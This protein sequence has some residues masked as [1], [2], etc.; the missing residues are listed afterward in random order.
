M[1]R[2]VN[3]IDGIV[4]SLKSQ[5]YCYFAKKSCREQSFDKWLISMGVVEFLKSQ[6]HMGWLRLVGSLKS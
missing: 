2:P 5:L 1:Q 4:E 3:G 6:L